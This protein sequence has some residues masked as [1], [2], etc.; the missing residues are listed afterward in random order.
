MKRFGH[1]PD[2]QPTE[3]LKPVRGRLPK[4]VLGKR[5]PV[6]RKPVILVWFL[7]SDG[8]YKPVV[9]TK[10][11]W[12]GELTYIPGRH[13]H[14][15]PNTCEYFQRVRLTTRRRER[16]EDRESHGDNVLY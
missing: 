13:Q 2:V 5:C 4:F 7:Q 9:I 3:P 10:A 16:R 6:C 15:N 8:S 1:R 12:Q 11:S 14:H